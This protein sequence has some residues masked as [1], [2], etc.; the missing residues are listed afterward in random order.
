MASDT[1]TARW[2]YR[3]ARWAAIQTSELGQTRTIINVDNNEALLIARA[4]ARFI[5][6]ADETEAEAEA[7][8]QEAAAGGPQYKKPKEEQA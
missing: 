6:D 5:D 8:R 2:V 7:A 4:A 1:V 3:K